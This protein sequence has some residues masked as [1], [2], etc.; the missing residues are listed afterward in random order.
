[1]PAFEVT[2]TVEGSTRIEA[3]TADHAREIFDRRRIEDVVK[4]DGD[5]EVHDCN[6]IAPP[7]TFRQAWS[8]LG[9]SS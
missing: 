6:A 8:R 3:D 7:E 5:L 2:W 4:H 1:M 9:Q